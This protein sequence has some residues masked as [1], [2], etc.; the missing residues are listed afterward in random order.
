M[1]NKISTTQGKKKALIV[2]VSDYDNLPKEKQ[3]PFCRND[4][5]GIYQVLHEQGFEIPDDWKL[6]GRV[7]SKQLKDAIFDFFRT[8]TESRDTLVFY[9]SGH[10]VPD[11]YGEHYLAPSDLKTEL[12][13]Y[14]GFKFTDLEDQANKSPA[15]KIIRILD[16][17]FSGAAEAKT[18]G[19]EDVAKS[20]RAA[21]DKTFKEGDGKCVLASSLADQE[22]F[23]KKD[24]PYSLFTSCVLEGL[25]GGKEGRAINLEG[26]VTPYTLGNYVYHRMM[27]EN[28]RQKPITKTEMSGDIIL[29][30][31]PKLIKRQENEL[32]LQKSVTSTSSETK[33]DN[34]V[35]QSNTALTALL[36][37]ARK[38]YVRREYRKADTLFERVL[39]IDPNHIEGL[40]SKGISLY[41]LG[42]YDKAKAC[43]NKVLEIDP[44]NIVALNNVEILSKK[45]DDTR[46]PSPNDANSWI[47]QGLSLYNENK[48]E[49]AL[50]H[51]DKAIELDPNNADAWNNKGTSL[52]FLGKHKEAIVCFDEA[53]KVEPNHSTAQNNKDKALEMLRWNQ[54]PTLPKGY[55]K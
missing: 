23:K 36:E 20:A 32:A 9:F 19:E 35:S 26:Y 45:I 48:F 27:D 24:E 5:D 28:R 7:T 3:L 53:M 13:E 22:S 16:C 21:I 37:S 54:G 39:E 15:R 40:N 18:G 55:K 33:D 47:R 25:N 10:G 34:S 49:E 50:R 11:G 38:Y 12:P 2:A 51:Y 44:E 41:R 17:C 43:F 8:R 6:I 46:V 31:H 4:G 1:E 52:F 29:A 42:E 14:Y 30:Y